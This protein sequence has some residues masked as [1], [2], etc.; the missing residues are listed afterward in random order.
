MFKKEVIP[1]V[2]GMFLLVPG[3]PASDP[4]TV[5]A[6]LNDYERSSFV[7]AAYGKRAEIA[8]QLLAVDG[9]SRAMLGSLRDL[10]ARVRFADEK[11]GYALILVRRDKVLDVLDLPGVSSASAAAIDRDYSNPYQTPASVPSPVEPKTAPVPPVAIPFPRVASDLPEKGPYFAAA[12]AGLS[13]LW[14]Q[15]PE[16]DGRGVRIAVLDRGLDLLHPALL[17]AKDRS[18]QSVPKVADVITVT[19]PEEDA[20]WVQFGDPIKT[21]NGSLVAAGRTWTAPHDGKFRFG[22]FTRELH[23]GT[24]DWE[25]KDPHLKVLALSVGVLWDEQSGRAWVDTDGDGSFAKEQALADYSVAHDVGYFGRKQGQD[26]NRIPF[27]IKIDRAR[28]AAYLSIADSPHGGL[29]AGPLAANRRTGGLFEGA[30][31]NAQLLDARLPSAHATLSLILS[32]FARNDVEVIHKSGI[33]AVPAED[34]RNDF[35]RHV[36]ERA[37]AV[38][39]KPMACYCGASNTIHVLDYQ[40]PEML[41]RNRQLPPPYAE[42]MNGFVWFTA[43]GLVNTVLAPSTSLVTESRYMPFAVP[44]EDGRLHVS[45][46]TAEPSAPAGYGIGANPSPTIPV[47]SGILADLVS[48]ARR[49]HVRYSAV[50]LTQAVLTGASFVHGFPAF[51]Q[52]FGLVNAAAAW[53]QLVKMAKA[54]DP[55]NPVLTSFVVARTEGADRKEV[56]GFQADLPRSGRTIEGE[57]WITRKGGYSGARAYRLALR[58]DDG[59]YELLDRAATFVRDQ[60]A[61]LRFSARITPGLHVA[62]LQLLDTKAGVVMQEIPLS[63]RAPDV[64]ETVAPGIEKYQ[65]TIPPLRSDTRYVRVGED[66]QAARFAMRIPYGGPSFISARSIP[67]FRYGVV[68]NRFT[69]TEKPAG[70][71]VDAAHHVGP[72]E[73]F[74]SLVA[75]DRP[76]IQTIFW[77]NRGRPEYATPY[78]PPAP[79]VPITGTLTVTRYAVFFAKE[80]DQSLRVT[81]KLADIEGRVEWYDAKLISSDVSGA[82]SHALA[83]IERNLP[84]HLSQWR[85]AVSAASPQ[86]DVVDAFLLNCTGKQGCVVAAQ[87]SI[88][89]DGAKL[90]VDAPEEGDWKIVIRK[91]EEDYRTSSYRV[92]E[93]LLVAGAS[94][95]EP[96]DAKHLSGTTWSVSLPPTRSDAQYVAFRIS[97][98]PGNDLEKNGVRIAMTPLAAGIP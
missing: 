48:E 67:G 26:D 20:G 92:R 93:A 91:R 95:I 60:P 56:N 64:P 5:R 63:L 62:F 33:A 21:T 61:R 94:A 70:Q 73:E 66:T 53:D 77:E 7:S 84:A 17:L 58:G 35:E 71:P 3:S 43:D 15:H 19:T 4:C 40:S 31:P 57:L 97:G 45:E 25:Q 37:M 52:G 49:T 76:A 6:A 22:I 29:I 30:A 55:E 87:Q 78:D 83:A 74:E 50:R 39:D 51:Q 44:W 47:V 38:Y 88:G 12:E 10:A 24:W 90:V 98:K 86:A 1:L 32:A 68:G 79:D 42:T 65:A 36:L 80:S 2:L 16:A 54:D 18:G 89:K 82:E 46:L 59:T 96:G 41:R 28:R 14:R 13:A 69:S 27:G 34:G 9:C 23:L 81:N 72:M 11:V 8:V 85:V 75:N